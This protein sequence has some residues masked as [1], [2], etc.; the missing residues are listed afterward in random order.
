MAIQLII[1]ESQLKDL[2]ILRD[3]GPETIKAI[4]TA[5]KEI[6]PP[7][8]R[9]AD[10]QKA[11]QKPLHN[12]TENV[13]TI[14]SLLISLYNLCRHRDIGEDELFEGLLYG[15]N[16]TQPSIRWGKEE[17]D[18]WMD[19]KPLL[20]DLFSLTPIW[21]VCKALELA[22]DYTNL[23]QKAKIITDIRPIYSD[24]ATEIQGAVVS[25]TL[26]LSFDSREGDRDISIALDGKDVK[27]LSLACDR[28]LTKAK[29]AKSLLIQQGINALISGEE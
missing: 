4:S 26:R 28:A 20:M 22:Y 18:K 16:N 12:Q 15:I 9:P 7:A 5:L 8:I 23:F 2:T 25:Y 29:V 11:L 19:L 10:L 1:R 24:S 27:K 3:L 13:D 14:V 21:N 6:H 17:I